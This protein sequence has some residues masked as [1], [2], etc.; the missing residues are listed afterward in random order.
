M[1]VKTNFLMV[2]L[3]F[4]TFASTSFADNKYGSWLR[5]H[6]GFS[7][8]ENARILSTKQ[9]CVLTNGSTFI[10]DT[11]HNKADPTLFI[12]N[13][14]FETS[15]GEK[16]LFSS[17]DRGMDLLM[18]DLIFTT[19]FRSTPEAK[20]KKWADLTFQARKTTLFNT[21]M[22]WSGW[23]MEEISHQFTM[24]YEEQSKTYYIS[25]FMRPHF[26]L[27]KNNNVVIYEDTLA[28]CNLAIQ[29]Q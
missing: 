29:I 6:K 19:D 27:V 7:L 22:L 26:H 1:N 11:K 16:Y 20:N 15:A 5:V 18:A 2:T 10:M 13:V 3:L 24:T 14:K 12:T 23:E 25:G 28:N 9:S 8:P 4:M 21:T 17:A